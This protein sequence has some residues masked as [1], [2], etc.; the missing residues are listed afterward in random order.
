[1]NRSTPLS[2]DARRLLELGSNVEPPTAE[3]NER[4]DRALASLFR[5]GRPAPTPAASSPLG[6]AQQRSTSPHG[7][8]GN[9]S[10]HAPGNG[11]LQE[12]EPSG[13][14]L[15]IAARTTPRSFDPTLG[16]R[17]AKLWLTLGALAAT[18]SASFW[19]GRLSTPGD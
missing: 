10:K 15:R 3:Q 18:A 9:G 13:V 5:A 7:R 19:L 14:R 12:H 4:M 11:H 16:L 17:D 8:R 2:A 1:M 6:R